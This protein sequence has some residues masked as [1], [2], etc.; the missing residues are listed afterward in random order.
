M[1]FT[2]IVLPS[3]RLIACR[4]VVLL[5][6]SLGLHVAMMRKYI[7]YRWVLGECPSIH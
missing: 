7:R 6:T 3:L 1:R 2:D 4:I 5:D